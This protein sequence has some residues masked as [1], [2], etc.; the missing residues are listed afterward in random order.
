MQ[1]E[2]TDYNKYKVV[3]LVGE[4]DLHNSR[5]VR[6]VLLDQINDSNHLL[7]DFSLLTY[8]DSSG[9]ATLIEALNSAK[10]KDLLFHIVAANGAPL[11]V[12][13]LTRLDSVFS[14][15]DSFDVVDGE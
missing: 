5:E 2:L 6:A 1:I 14:M 9:V 10:T 12:L 7:V 3:Q 8:I 4:V 15:K 13:Q 11:Q